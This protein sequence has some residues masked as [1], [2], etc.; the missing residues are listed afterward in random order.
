MIGFRDSGNTFQGLGFRIWGNQE[1]ILQG[2]GFGEKGGI[3]Y[4][5]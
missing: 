1:N 3:Y 5:V 2:F 4:K